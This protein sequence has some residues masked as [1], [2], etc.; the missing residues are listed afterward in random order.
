MLGADYMYSPRDR[1]SGYG[2]MVSMTLPWLS[3]RHDDEVRQAEHSVTADQHAYAA[4]RATARYQ[5]REALT[6]YRSAQ[7]SFAL[8]DREL[9]AQAQQSF[10]AAQAAYAAG[11]GS[12]AAILDAAR[13]LLEVR[14]G[15]LRALTQVQSSLADLERAVGRPIH[16]DQP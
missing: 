6:R 5:V 10:E 7:A 8:I 2:A 3:A 4:A 12:A 11:Q 15:R 9:A 16:G 13:A 1:M 14:I